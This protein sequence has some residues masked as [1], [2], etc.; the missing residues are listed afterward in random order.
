[1]LLDMI[2]DC[3]IPRGCVPFRFLLLSR[4]SL[5]NKLNLV[6]TTSWLVK[7]AEHLTAGS[8]GRGHTPQNSEG[9]RQTGDRSRS[10]F[11][12]DESIP[13][14]FRARLQDYFR[15]GYDRGHMCV[16]QRKHLASSDDNHLT[17]YPL[18]YQLPMQKRV[19]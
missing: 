2:G 12:E 18:G 17:T 15:S 10:T 7:T 19:K 5:S 11:S 8:L 9:V 14:P 13:P 1:M 16:L 6:K 4:Y 3:G